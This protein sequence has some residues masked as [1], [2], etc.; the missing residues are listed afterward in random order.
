MSCTVA[1]WVD[2][3]LPL[4]DTVS[5]ETPAVAVLAAVRFRTLV[6]EAASRLGGAKVPVTPAGNP[7]TERDTV[8]V[9]LPPLTMTTVTTPV[10]PTFMVTVGVGALRVSVP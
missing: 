8:P 4:A 5:V 1:V 9:K 3:P 10:P 2:T 6:V 7:V